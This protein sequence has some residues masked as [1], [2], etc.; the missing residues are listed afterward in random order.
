MRKVARLFRGEAIT[1]GLALLFVAGLLSAVPT[2]S[3]AET[4]SDFLESIAGSYS[5]RGK[6]KFIGDKLDTVACKIKNDFES[7]KLAVTG[8]C[9]STKGKGKVNGGITASGDT[10]AG[11]FVAPKPNLEITQSSGEFA[12]GKMTLSTSMIDNQ[13]GGL[14]RVRQI[15]TKIDDGIRAEFFRYDNMSKSYKESGSIELKKRK[16]E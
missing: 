9:A 8:E 11:T 4:A 10:V 16:S 14:I 6:A 13:K 7:G 5:G 15:I 12:D 3:K 1:A 2:Q